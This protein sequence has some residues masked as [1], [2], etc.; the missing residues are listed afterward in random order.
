[1]RIASVCLV[2]ALALAPTASAGPLDAEAELQVGEGPI[3]LVV[4]AGVLIYA[5]GLSG[6][7]DNSTPP[8]EWPDAV[9]VEAGEPLVVV[10]NGAEPPESIEL[11]FWSKLRRNGLPKKPVGR[12]ECFTGPVP[13]DC[14]LEPA[15]SEDGDP[16]WAVALEGPVSSGHLYMSANFTWAN[17]PTTQAVWIFHARILGPRSGEAR[18]NKRAALVHLSPL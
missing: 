5:N 3:P 7:V 17:S 9:E 6:E 18:P 1:M 15:V 2:I 16:G 11:R 12:S 8:V 10:A 14:D 13:L 4:Q